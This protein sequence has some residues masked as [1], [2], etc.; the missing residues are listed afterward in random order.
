M[1]HEDIIGKET[2]RRLAVD[3][4]THLRELSI[5]PDSLE[6]LPTEHL[7]IEDRR[8]DPVVKLRE[9]EEEPFP[10]RGILCTQHGAKHWISRSARNDNRNFVGHQSDDRN[11]HPVPLL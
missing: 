11:M 10:K 5:D 4:A 2:I 9:R 6:I 7:R 1:P 8:A 3:L